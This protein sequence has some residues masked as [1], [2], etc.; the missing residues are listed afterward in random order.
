MTVPDDRH[1][2]RIV[3][4]AVRGDAEAFGRIYDMYV[5]RIYGFVKSR[6]RNAH[7]A[8]DITETV[9]LKAFEAIKSYDRRG[10]PFGAWLFRI[11]R[12]ATVDHVRRQGRIPDPVEDLEVEAGA[13]DTRVDEEAIASA[14]AVVVREAVASL[15]DDQAD[16]IT[17]RFL[18]DMDIRA[19]AKAL[20]RTEG[21]VKALQ[22][23]ALRNL[24]RMLEDEGLR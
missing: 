21:A 24:A 7:D 8:E 1:V 2:D 17:C 14:D 20:D 10:L 23:R 4:R 22:H 19:T 12:N 15:T 3:R 6:V 9:F 5:D 18:F 11:A 16:V 13:A